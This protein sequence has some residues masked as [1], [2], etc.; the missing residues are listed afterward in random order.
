MNKDCKV[1]K[2]KKNRLIFQKGNAGDL[3]KLDI[4]I[5]SCYE[6]LLKIIFYFSDLRAT[7]GKDP[8]LGLAAK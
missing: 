7:L 6:N 8:N 4:H 2:K 5:S 1:E 3:V